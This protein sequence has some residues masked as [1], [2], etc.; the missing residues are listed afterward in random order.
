MGSKLKLC[1][2]VAVS[3]LA[4]G[5]MTT[6]S[7]N[8]A[9][10]YA[11][12]DVIADLLASNDG[13]DAGDITFATSCD[14]QTKF[15]EYPD[16]NFNIADDCGAADVSDPQTY[17]LANDLSFQIQ[18]QD[19]WV[20]VEWHVDTE[21]ENTSFPTTKKGNPKVGDFESNY[22]GDTIL[23]YISNSG[24]PPNGSVADDDVDVAVHAVVYKPLDCENELE[25]GVGECD[26]DE[27]ST[28]DVCYA[29]DDGNYY[30]TALEACGSNFEL[31]GE[32]AW[33]D[34][35]RFVSGKRSWATYIND[36]DE[37]E[38]CNWSCSGDTCP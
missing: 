27:Y 19:D 7:A 23:D 38:F 36:L 6:A 31:N 1:I 14:T 24:A 29:D 2:G 21:D 22:D 37:T 33:S 5:A 11:Y 15:C 26:S 9:W 17:V 25:E 10:S 35:T 32:S 28:D 16:T 3:A 8:Q 20:M 13:M 4:M 34:G 12:E 18:T 30:L